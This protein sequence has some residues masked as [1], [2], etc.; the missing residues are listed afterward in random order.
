MPPAQ[1]TVDPVSIAEEELQQSGGDAKAAFYSLAKKKGV[2][3][4]EFLKQIS[5]MGDPSKLL[6]EMITKNSRVGSLMKM[7]SGMK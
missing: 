3:T 6:Q 7:F 1:Q 4:D 5:S 2:N